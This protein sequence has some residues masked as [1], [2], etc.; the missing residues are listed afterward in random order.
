MCDAFDGF[1]PKRSWHT[2]CPLPIWEGFRIDL[3]Q[4]TNSTDALQYDKA[5]ITEL[6]PFRICKRRKIRILS[7]QAAYLF[8]CKDKDMQDLLTLYVSE[9]CQLSIE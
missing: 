1:V 8:K 2:R 5:C 4:N 9:L 6:E 7:G 3:D